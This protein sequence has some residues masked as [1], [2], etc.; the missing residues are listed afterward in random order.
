MYTHGLLL[1]AQ[2]DLEWLST[3]NC[4]VSQQYSC[5]HEVLLCAL[6]SVLATGGREWWAPSGGRAAPNT[7]V[8]GGE[9]L[10]GCEG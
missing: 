5:Q 4:T 8:W 9:W 6:W 3:V 10:N 7:H 2:V 1:C